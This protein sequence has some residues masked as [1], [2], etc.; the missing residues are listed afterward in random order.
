M[1]SEWKFFVIVF[2]ICN[3]SHHR[4]SVR[5]WWWGLPLCANLWGLCNATFHNEDGYCWQ[6]SVHWN[7]VMQLN[8][9]LLL[10][11]RQK[12]VF[13]LLIYCTSTLC[14]MWSATFSCL[15]FIFFLF[16][17]DITTF[18]RL[19]LRKEGFNFHSSS[20][21]EIVRTIKEVRPNTVALV[22]ITRVRV[23]ESSLIFYWNHLCAMVID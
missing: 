20:E 15:F 8:P 6:V 17:R 12:V 18:L 11:K 10:V 14:A 3:W 1:E 2:Q 5:F 23:R 13:F 21:M 4:C 22:F 19:L 16:N 7:A 9:F